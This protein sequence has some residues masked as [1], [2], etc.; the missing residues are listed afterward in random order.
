MITEALHDKIE[1]IKAELLTD[2]V[3]TTTINFLVVIDDDAQR[4][5]VL[6]RV[7]LIDDKHPARTIV[8]DTLST[9]DNAALNNDRIEIPTGAM[10]PEDVRSLVQ[11]L[12]IP[13]IPSVLWWTGDEIVNQPLFD[14]L[15]DIVD[16][17]VIDSSGS[18]TDNRTVRDLA[19]FSA[20]RPTVAVR[21]LAW[22]RLHPWQDMIAHFF[23]DPNLMEELF[24]IRK[25]EIVSG[26]EAEALYLGGWLA[27]RLGWTAC[28]H[29]EFC[30]RDGAAIPFTHRREGA[31]RRVRRVCV[32]TA[33]STY[34]AALA[35]SDEGVVSVGVTGEKARPE[36]LV[37]LQSIDNASLIERAILE[38]PADEVFET[39]L[40]MVGKILS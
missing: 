18:R 32:E 6:D 16:A 12:M 1:T 17:L 27:S 13:E 24:A 4:Q 33:A 26:S 9:G 35:P 21:D 5:W 15:I 37:P 36:R 38:P 28:A 11:G 2:T 20:R 7:T 39:A 10:S 31:G 3:A 25:L 19:E 30:D 8:L 34:V 23:D 40:H 29:D 14:P 22:M